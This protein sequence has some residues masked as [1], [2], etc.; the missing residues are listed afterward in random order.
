M[1]TKSWKLYHRPT[2][3]GTAS[4]PQP[5]DGLNLEIGP[6]LEGHLSRFSTIQTHSSCRF[7][8]AVDFLGLRRSGSWSQFID[9]PQDFPKQVPGHGNLGQLEREV[10]A[11]ADNLGPDLDHP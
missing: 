2:A 1:T 10:P 4:L 7:H 8:L 5:S 11:V 3:K 9:P 6:R